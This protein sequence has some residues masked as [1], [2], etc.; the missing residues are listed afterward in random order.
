MPA[1]GSSE[2]TTALPN[3]CQKGVGSGW[4]MAEKHMTNQIHLPSSSPKS[5][6]K[7]KI[8]VGRCT[9]CANTSNCGFIQKQGH[10]VL[11]YVVHLLLNVCVFN[12]ANKD[13]I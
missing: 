13:A 1:E 6:K 8:L 5:E 3:G 2:G 12:S 9:L 7:E 4:Q 10:F 11:V